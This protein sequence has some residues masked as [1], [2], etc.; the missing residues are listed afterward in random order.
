MDTTQN[1]IR[2]WLETN[3]SDIVAVAC[4]ILVA[5]LLTHFGEKIISRAVKRA[6]KTDIHVTRAE[7]KKR[8]ETITH[9]I[10]GMLKV[11][12]WP[13]AIMSII[14]Q[15][16]VE[17]APLIAGAGIIGLALGFGAQTLV[18]DIIAGLF[19][20]IENQYGVGDVV[21][22]DGTAGT[23]EE[24][25]LR[26][27]RLRDTAG[28]VHHVPNGTIL[29]ASNMTSEFSGISLNV[30]VAYNSDMD[31]VVTIVNKVGDE[32]AKDEKWMSKII[33]APQFV[34]VDNFGPFSVDVRIMGKVKP[35]SQWEVTG[36]LRLRLIDAFAH[37]H[38]EMPTAPFIGR[39]P[40]PKSRQ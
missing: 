40:I 3:Q 28:V 10:G 7:E 32:L 6:V 15:L 35:L 16:G 38:I 25:T 22:L 2:N 11:I 20:I 27:T 17:I 12:V 31:K 26:K 5:I 37:A 13:L 24:I 36:E 1:G 19:I 30:G 4:I 39:E 8:E 33:E 21:D 23:V 34:R 9:I 18:K 14:G 29:R